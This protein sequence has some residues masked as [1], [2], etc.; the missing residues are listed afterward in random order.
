MKEVEKKQLP[1]V[2]GGQVPID[3]PCLPTDWP[4]PADYPENPSGPVPV[5]AFRITPTKTN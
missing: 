3:G 2:S 5:D 4:W 1:E